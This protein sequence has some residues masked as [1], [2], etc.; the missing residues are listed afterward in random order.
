MQLLTP[1]CALFALVGLLPLAAAAY[2]DRRI[3]AVAG[4]LGLTAEPGA[5]RGRVAAATGAAALLGLAASQPVLTATRSASV[6]RDAAVLFVLDTSRSMAASTTPTS[7]TR[8]DRAV[9]AAVQLRDAIPDVPAGVA[10]LTDRVLPDLL[11]VPDVAGFDAVVERAVEI[12]SPPP[13]TTAVRATSYD[14]LAGIASGNYFAPGV[15]KRIVVLLTDGESSPVDTSSLANELPAARGYRLVA[16]RFWRGDEA[17]YDETGKAEPGYHPDPT[18]RAILAQLA[19]ALGGGSY[20]ETQLGGAAG[21]LRSLVGSGPT[22]RT[23]VAAPAQHPLAP[24][25]AGLALLLALAAAA[26][27]RPRRRGVHLPA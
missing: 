6:R 21:E 16:V 27:L 25:L 23:H 20:E 19:G 22:V 3:R 9:G 13:R 24:W 7:P 10:T 26:P 1:F 5:Q 8:L 11:P 14:A 15:T 17:V 2:G 18:G 12:E 4:V